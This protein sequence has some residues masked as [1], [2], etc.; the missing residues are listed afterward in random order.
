LTADPLGA[1][2]V[3]G[4]PVS[5]RC[6][7]PPDT[8]TWLLAYAA[9][10]TCGLAGPAAAPLSHQL[11]SH[12]LVSSPVPLNSSSK[13]GLHAP[14]DDQLGVAGEL[15]VVLGVG[16]GDGDRGAG[17]GGGAG[18]VAVGGGGAELV[19]GVVGGGLVDGAD[20]GWW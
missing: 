16:V 8:D 18:L 12:R 6:R 3:I 2:A 9:V 4:P 15:P 5:S 20:D 1:I 7:L 19:A 11:V 14:A 13:V 17:L 10:S